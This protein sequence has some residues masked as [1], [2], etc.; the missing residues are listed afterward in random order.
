MKK[1]LITLVFILAICCSGFNGPV[2]AFSNEEQEIMSKLNSQV[3]VITIDGFDDTSGIL[4]YNESSITLYFNKDDLGLFKNLTNDAKKS[5]MNN[6][7][8]DHWGDYLG[9]SICYVSVI[10]DGK[11]YAISK[12]TY[13]ASY[14]NIALDYFDQGSTNLV[15]WISPEEYSNNNE[16]FTIP[17]KI[18]VVKINENGVVINSNTLLPAAD[19]IKALGGTVNLNTKT[20]DI[21]FSYKDT[22]VQ[23]K[24]NSKSAKINGVSTSYAGS[25]QIVSGKL[26]IPLQLI[27]DLFGASLN[28]EFDDTSSGKKYIKSVV[29]STDSKEVTVPVNDLYE[30]YKKYYGKTVWLNTPTTLIDD[31]NGNS[32]HSKVQNLSSVTIKSI[33][34]DATLGDW[35]NVY[36]SY[37]GQTYRAT[38]QRRNFPLAI[39]TENPYKTYNFSQKNWDRIQKGG[40]NIGMTS[41]MVFLSWGPYSRHSKD[42]YSWGT[43]DLWVYE[44]S[45]GA[46]RYLY[47]ENDVLKS[48]STY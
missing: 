34:R 4:K 17:A 5:F 42:I 27:K 13:G 23:T 14:E 29:I 6:L 36:F 12:T 21:N 25:F 35:L 11:L 46:D 37:K 24:L 8:Q 32:A 44:S 43:T 19:V 48:I 47:F 33:T 20:N 30:T 9:A 15:P 41:D 1:F 38:L 10:Y 31:L 16:T 2:Y 39:L 22:K 45:L 26:M 18:T 28:V 7:A 40:I 3:D